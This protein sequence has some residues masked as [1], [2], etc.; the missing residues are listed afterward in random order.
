[1]SPI[2]PPATLGVLGGGQLGRMFAQAAQQMGYRVAVIDPDR[3]AP[4]LQVADVPI[5]GRYDDP[6]AL[7][8][9][10]SVCAAVTVELESIP[11]S[12]VA[13]LAQE[14]RVAPGA[15]AI[16]IA[17]DRLREKRF[18]RAISLPVVP[19]VE[20]LSARDL[21]SAGCYPGILKSA[22]NGYDG[23]GQMSVADSRAALEAWRAFGEVPCVLER[24][25]PL[26]HELSVIVARGDDGAVR[27]FPPAEN[28][29]RD[30][31]LELSMAPAWIP[32]PLATRAARTARAIAE[33]LDYVGVLGVEFF[34][35]RGELFVNEFAPRPHNSGHYTIEACA[36]SQFEQQV[37]ALCGLPLGETTLRQAAAMANI[38][39][40]AWR[41]GEPDFGWM[42]STTGATLH[43]YGKRAASA[44]RKMGHVTFLGERSRQL[45]ERA[46]RR[47]KGARAA[48][49]QST[50]A[51]FP[52]GPLHDGARNAST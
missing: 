32:A 40:D 46:L 48:R 52:L 25:V 16:A 47:L 38:L 2:R 4:A 10:A 8:R 15:E 27:T 33:N 28:R 39:G 22:R 14:C 44:R 20:V 9:L 24:R 41:Q 7:A 11:T 12:S 43:L 35:S 6:E 18:L 42:R 19:F 37:R 34:V 49:G 50:V 3:D 23:R 5:V 26:D 21:E 13:R 30:G 51:P 31:I 36:T 17:Q 29:H 1:M 45:A